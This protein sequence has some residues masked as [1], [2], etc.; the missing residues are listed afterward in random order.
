VNG[1]GARNH[2]RNGYDGTTNLHARRPLMDCKINVRFDSLATMRMKHAPKAP[3]APTTSSPGRRRAKL[4]TILSGCS[5]RTSML[6]FRTAVTLECGSEGRTLWAHRS[7][8][9]AR[10]VASLQLSETGCSQGIQASSGPS[11]KKPGGRRALTVASFPSPAQ[12]NLAL[13]CND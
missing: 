9:T 5:G 1:Y 10:R 3:A 7:L 13:R 6:I 11:R 8:L 12:V 2:K 4:L